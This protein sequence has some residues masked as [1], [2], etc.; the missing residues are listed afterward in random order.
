[1]AGGGNYD[2]G[3]GFIWDE[4]EG[5]TSLP[6][7]L[8]RLDDE[9]GTNLWDFFVDAGMPSMVTGISADNKRIGGTA[10]PA[11]PGQPCNGFLLILP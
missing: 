11:D 4:N 10:G 8:L 5:A 1:M 7:L 2:A 6:E 9:Y 3:S